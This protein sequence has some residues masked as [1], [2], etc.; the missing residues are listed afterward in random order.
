MAVNVTCPGCRTSYPV[1]EDLLGKK[2]RCKKCQETFAATAAKSAVTARA[3]DER[4][5]TRPPAKGANG[6]Y[7]DEDDAPRRNGNGHARPMA[8]RP[9]AKSGGN[10]GLLI[11]GIAGGVLLLAAGV[12]V[13]VWFFNKDDAASDSNSTVSNT[14]PTITN[15]TPVKPAVDSAPKAEPEKTAANDGADHPTMKTVPPVPKFR[16]ARIDSAVLKQKEKSAVLIRVTMQDG[17]AEGSGWFAEPGIIV[18]NSHVVG[19]KE[20]AVPPPEKIEIILYSGDKEKEDN[21][22]GELLA[23]DRDEDLAVI[24][25]RGRNLPPPLT[26]VPSADMRVGEHLIIMGFPLGSSIMRDMGLSKSTV[27][28]VKTR[29][30]PISG[31][32]MNKDGSVKYLETEGGADHGNSGG[33]VMD[34][35]GNV[36]AI[37]VAGLGGIGS[38]LRFVIPS[39]YATYLLQGRI[40]RM[41]PGPASTSGGGIIQPISVQIADPL[42]RIRRVTADVWP[43]KPGPMRPAATSQPTPQEGDGPR[44]NLDFAYDPNQRIELGASLNAAGEVALPAL[45]PNQVYWFQPHYYAADGKERWGQAVVVDMGRYPV[46][47]RPVKLAAN[48]KPGHEHR[49]ELTSNAAFS[50]E[51]QGRGRNLGFDLTATFSEKVRSRESNGDSKVRMQYTDLRMSDPTEDSQ[52]R[53]LLR[54]V[55]EQAKFL[56]VDL[57][58][59]DEGIIKKSITDAAGVSRAARPVLEL[60]NDQIVKSLNA[61]SVSLPNREVQPGDSW[62]GEVTHTVDIGLK[63][64]NILF[65]VKYTYLGVRVRDGRSEAVVT[66]TGRVIRDGDPSLTRGGR[67]GAANAPP[68]GQAPQEEENGDGSKNP[69]HGLSVGVALIDIETGELTLSRSLVDMALQT[70]LNDRVVERTAGTIDVRLRRTDKSSSTKVDSQVK[71]PTIDDL[72]PGLPQ[73]YKPVVVE[74]VAPDQAAAFPSI[75]SVVPP[76]DLLPADVRRKVQKSAVLVQVVRGDDATTGSGWVAEAN[77]VIITNAHILGMHAKEVHSHPPDGLTVVFDSGPPTVRRIAAKIVAVDWAEDLAV[78]RVDAPNLPEPLPM[79]PAATLTPPDRL[80]DV[81]FPMADYGKIMREKL[82]EIQVNVSIRETAV[83]GTILNKD[84]GAIRRVQ[85]EGAADPGNLGGAVVDP[86][87]N[88]RGVLAGT[89]GE[90]EQST[91]GFFT[92]S[93]FAA[94]MLQGYP[95]EMPT[96]RAYMNGSVATQPVRI[97]FSDPVKRVKKVAVDYWV[98]DRGAP[99]PATDKAPKAKPGDGP[100]QTIELAYDG[101]LQTANGEFKLPE[102]SPGQ[103]L[104]LQPRFINGTGKEQW[105]KTTI[106]I[107]DGPPVDRTKVVQLEVN[108]RKGNRRDIELTTA[109]DIHF[110]QFGQETRIGSPFKT[111]I[112][113]NVLDV[114]KTGTVRLQ[115][116]YQFLELDLKKIYPVLEDAPPEIEASFQRMMRP[117]LDFIRGVITLVDVTKDGRMLQVPNGISYARV[118]QPLQEP[119]AKFNSQ[120]LVSLQALTFPMPSKPVKYGDTWEFPTNLFVPSKNKVEGA[121]FKMKF[122]FAGVRQQGGRREAVIEITGSLTGNSGVKGLEMSGAEAQP[123]AGADDKPEIQNSTRLQYAPLSGADATKSRKGLYGDAHGFAVVDLDGGFVSKVNLSIDLEVELM[124]LDRQTKHDVPVLASGTMDLRLLRRTGK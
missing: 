34:T 43:G 117:L 27:V 99:R 87:G 62:E 4:I 74:E 1:T 107:P 7:D 101:D 55:I 110:S 96:E 79:L 124:V 14:T 2:I 64:R 118:P 30:A 25:V 33:A 122:K 53:K 72:L 85:I 84:D 46:E 35:N 23:I 105:T 57:T 103:I 20:A 3:T 89:Y 73:T 91:L 111:A 52:Y 119:M 109:T 22:S 114:K 41:T 44:A 63:P 97:K 77:G 36:V 11:G 37:L 19:M 66:M 112:T 6:R 70:P 49:V 81:G 17:I 8:K 12:G 39:E 50:A 76:K 108:N 115:L 80:Y 121:L 59:S 5:T 32:I 47:K 28:T 61:M 68:A 24:R 102:M 42:K 58:I 26:I 38:T 18:T 106:F 71:A 93:E 83:G 15:G 92:P 88:V 48:Y 104:W 29:D 95:M 60:F 40:L 94:R 51:I 82:E 45:E 113:E 21:I 9:P 16:P 86:K 10:K 100:H 67:G 78:L 98:G 31:R 56:G 116:I 65:R 69:R 75:E 54:G 120:V 123:D 13:G 90:V